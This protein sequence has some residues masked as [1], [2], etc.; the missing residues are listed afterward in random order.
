M[1]FDWLR[2]YM[3]FIYLEMRRTVSPGIDTTAAKDGINNHPSN[4]NRK[5]SDN[6]NNNY[7][8]NSDRSDSISKSQLIERCLCLPRTIQDETVACVDTNVRFETPT[9]TDR[10]S[11]LIDTWEL[12]ELALSDGGLLSGTYVREGAVPCLGVRLDSTRLDGV[13]FQFRWLCVLH[14][15]FHRDCHCDDAIPSWDYLNGTF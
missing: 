8:N 7:N 15:A 2:L 13:A 6:N 3:V 12:R 5:S 14:F 9:D 1:V 11:S 4:N 10:A